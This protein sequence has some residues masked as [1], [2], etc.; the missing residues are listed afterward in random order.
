MDDLV[1]IIGEIRKYPE[2]KETI[3]TL[4]DMLIALLEQLKKNT[5]KAPRN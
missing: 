5:K 1:E 4:E 3:E 2:A